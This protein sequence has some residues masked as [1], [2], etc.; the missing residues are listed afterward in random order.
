MEKSICIVLAVAIPVLAVILAVLFYL[1]SRRSGMFRSGS[2]LPKYWLT[3]LASKITDIQQKDM[4]IGNHGDSFI[5]ITDLHYNANDGNS[6]GA[7]EYIL[8]RSSVGKVIIGGDICN[9]SSRGKPGCIDQILNC[10]NAFRKI[11][12]Y[13]LRGNHDNNT[14]ISDCTPEKELPDSELYDLILKPIENRIVCNHEFHYYF[15]NEIRKI[16]Y[17]CLD[18]GH[19]DS[20]VLPDAQIIWMQNVIR[21]LDPGWTV[22]VLTHQYYDTDGTVDGNGN[23]IL[24]GLNDVYDK[25]VATIACVICGHSH[26]DRL[27]IT[28]KGFPVICTTCD[29]RGGGDP[30][31]KRIRFTHTEQ[32]FDVYHIDTAARKIHVTRIGAGSDREATY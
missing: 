32:A 28:P 24:A 18:T 6:A 25:T 15:D 5:F 26:A 7:A 2:G 30:G 12:P 21:K 19:P 13:Y 20:Y 17:I 31:S 16:R 4:E 27:E 23:K 10:R 29:T 11:N 22:V 9:G 14:E 1:R 3:Y 8:D